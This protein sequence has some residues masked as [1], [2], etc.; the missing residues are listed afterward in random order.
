M[1]WQRLVSLAIVAAAAVLLLRREFGRRRFNFERGAGCG[2]AA[3]SRTPASGSI[4]FRA[5]K[6]ERPEIVVR[7]K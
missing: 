5:R 3:G 6:G 2:C 7:A 1:D 4:V